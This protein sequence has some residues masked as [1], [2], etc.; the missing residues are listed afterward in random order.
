M[1]SM[2]LDERGPWVH[3]KHMY[4]ILQYVMFCGIRKSF[5]HY[6]SWNWNEVHR[7]LGH[8][9]ILKLKYVAM[10]FDKALNRTIMG[11]IVSK[12]SLL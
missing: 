5:I 9:K 12:C 11:S 1:M 3:C 6:P 7:L 4:Y 10:S 2:S 8:A